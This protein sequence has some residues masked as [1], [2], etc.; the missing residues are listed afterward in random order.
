MIWYWRLTPC[1]NYMET[2]E[3]KCQR[4]R[5]NG[6][7]TAFLI[8]F[9]KQLYFILTSSHWI[10]K[11]FYDQ[12]NYYCPY[13]VISSLIFYHR[14]FRPDLHSSESPLSIYTSSVFKEKSCSIVQ[15]VYCIFDINII[16][17]TILFCLQCNVCIH[18]WRGQI[19]ENHLTQKMI[20]SRLDDLLQVWAFPKLCVTPLLPP[21]TVY[22]SF[23]ALTVFW[24]I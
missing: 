9:S 7:K 10:H 3:L 13:F 23:D 5:K 22:L 19:T 15:W 12:I 17:Y 18:T 8:F 6:R 16:R 20:W 11:L 21:S 24:N 14:H 4:R 1:T 2:D